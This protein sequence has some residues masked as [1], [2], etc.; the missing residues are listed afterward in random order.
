MYRRPDMCRILVGP[1]SSSIIVPLHSIEICQYLSDN[2]TVDKAANEHIVDLTN[3][4]RAFELSLTEKEFNG[5]YEF[6][7]TCDLSPG[8]HASHP[9]KLNSKQRNSYAEGLARAFVT[10]YKIQHEVLEEAIKH[11]L[12]A[13]RP[14]PP[15]AII[16]VAR[17]ICSMNLTDGATNPEKF[18]KAWIIDHV[19]CDFWTL[20]KY[21]KDS[22]KGL[23]RD[24]K[25]LRETVL[26]KVRE[27]LEVEYG[28]LGE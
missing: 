8:L 20:E 28:G 5:I 3:E 17:L 27:R 12:C 6:F 2:T 26:D 14:L 18:L 15:T 10:A 23:M 25:E 7:H 11:K 16:I 4:P 19:A 24:K 9:D 21:N 22:L 13:L 1:N